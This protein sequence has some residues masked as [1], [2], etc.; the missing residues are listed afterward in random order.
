ML[1]TATY[2]HQ[3][4]E[5]CV[6]PASDTLLLLLLLLL[7]PQGDGCAAPP[8]QPAAQPQAVSSSRP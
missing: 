6:V 1:L 2:L 4:F 5:T 7:L 8:A 3:Q